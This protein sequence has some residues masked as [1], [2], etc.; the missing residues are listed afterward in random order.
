MKTICRATSGMQL[1]NASQEIV[2]QSFFSPQ[3]QGDS[4]FVVMTNYIITEGQQMGKCPE[5]CENAPSSVLLSSLLPDFLSLAVFSFFSLRPSYASIN[6]KNETEI[7]SH[8]KT[9]CVSG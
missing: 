6:R 8:S 4:S 7:V 5:V 3:T 1:I 2:T 9:V